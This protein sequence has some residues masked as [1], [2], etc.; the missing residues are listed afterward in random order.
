MRILILAF[1]VLLPALPA[2]G[3]GEDKPGPNGGFIRMPGPYH[4]EI[5]PLGTNKIKVFLLD[6]NWKNPSVQKST[7]SIDHRSQTNV[8]ADCVIKDSISYLCSFPK[9]VDITKKGKLIV[10]S[11]REGQKGME[12]SYDLPLRLEPSKDTHKVHH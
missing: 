10:N 7:L 3:H 8:K 5:V 11:Q 4:T 12:T 9:D 1:A 6:I 2:W